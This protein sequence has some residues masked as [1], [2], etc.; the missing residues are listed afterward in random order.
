MELLLGKAS[1]NRPFS[2]A[3]LNNQRVIYPLVTMVN[4]GVM[5]NLMGQYSANNDGIP[6]DSD[7]HSY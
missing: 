1:I 5:V 7:P 3:M 2:M 4:D 6:S